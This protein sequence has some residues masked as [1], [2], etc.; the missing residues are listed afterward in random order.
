MG[1]S[2]EFLERLTPMRRALMGQWTFP[3][4]SFHMERLPFKD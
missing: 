4:Q 2:P 3:E 1:N